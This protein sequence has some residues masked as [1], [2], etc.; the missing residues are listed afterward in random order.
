MLV[1][2]MGLLGIILQLVIKLVRMM[3]ILCFKTYHPGTIGASGN[4]DVS[5]IGYA[6][7][8]TGNVGTGNYV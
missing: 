7:N 6:R 4:S 5:S 3:G 2:L 8:D 1:L